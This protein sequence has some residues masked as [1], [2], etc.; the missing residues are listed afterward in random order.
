M[1][2]FP[3]QVDS[4]D[5]GVESVLHNVM[6]LNRP[7][8]F[9]MFAPSLCS[10]YG[11]RSQSFLFM[12]RVETIIIGHFSSCYGLGRVCFAHSTWWNHSCFA[13]PSSLWCKAFPL[14]LLPWW[15]LMLMDT[16]WCLWSSLQHCLYDTSGLHCKTTQAKWFYPVLSEICCFDLHYTHWPLVVA[17][18]EVSFR[19]RIP[20]EFVG[21]QTT[22]GTVI[23][24][25]SVVVCWYCFST[26][27]QAMSCFPLCSG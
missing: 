20:I 24:V 1:S 25:C 15:S 27:C 16:H 8:Y 22:I 18:F 11:G 19:D 6:L 10:V 13:S 7:M 4:P 23:A 3:G 17:G 5:F 14:Y 12:R 2:A 9:T 26:W 21:W